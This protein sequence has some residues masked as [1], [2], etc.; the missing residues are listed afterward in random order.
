MLDSKS[1]I[2]QDKPDVMTYENPG[3][4]GS[5]D[6]FSN[7]STFDKIAESDLSQFDLNKKKSKSIGSQT[8]LCGCIPT[9][10][11]RLCRGASWP[12]QSPASSP[13]GPGGAWPQTR[14]SCGWF[15]PSGSSSKRVQVCQ[16][17]KDMHLRT[18]LIKLGGFFL[19]KKGNFC[20]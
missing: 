12:A 6:R 18:N 7:I 4:V 3:G 17:R 13:A 16:H 19:K 20:P 11:P 2:Y 9:S 10:R 14:R 1:L 8:L 15:R 5:T